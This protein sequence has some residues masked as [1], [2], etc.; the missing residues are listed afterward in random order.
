MDDCKTRVIHLQT[1]QSTL[2]TP[3]RDEQLQYAA[4]II[5]SGDVVAFPTE[6]V[7]GLGANALDQDASLKIFKVKNRPSDNPLIVHISSMNML[8]L[9][10][11]SVPD[12]ARILIE[13]FWPGPLT[14]LFT[15]TP[16][17]PDA[18][19]AGQPTVAVRMPSHPIARRLI[20][21][22]NTPI[23]APSANISGRPSPTT[24][25]DVLDDLN[26]RIKC[27]IDGGPCTFG[28]ESTVVDVNQNPP[29]ILRPGAVT[30]EKIREA[31]HDVRDLSLCRPSEPDEHFKPP[32]PGLK[33]RHY[34]PTAKVVLYEGS[35]HSI[36]K[37]LVHDVQTLLNSGK[38][39]GLVNTRGKSIAIPEDLASKIQIVALGN[40]ANLTPIAQHLFT[41]FREL[42]RLNV[43]TIL[44]MSVP[45]QKEGLAIMNRIRKAASEVIRA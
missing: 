22:S 29:A 20:Y 19:T 17:V 16:Q 24:A 41:T 36:Q 31:L 10:A 21:L 14:I 26:G 23:A 12:A 37:R 40:K 44:I 8:G 15:K 18:V 4:D 9:L 38:K 1:D 33:Y 43:D 2:F 5:R 6:T 35:S 7:Y 11:S 28:L 42:D 3:I 13:R 30:L 34:S 39:V 25:R 45:T 32:T 27:L